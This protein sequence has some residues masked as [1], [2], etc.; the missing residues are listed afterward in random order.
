MLGSLITLPLSPNHHYTKDYR[1]AVFIC[2][3]IPRSLL[4]LP[5]LLLSYTRLLLNSYSEE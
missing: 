4:K 1:A 5:E 2:Y 3:N